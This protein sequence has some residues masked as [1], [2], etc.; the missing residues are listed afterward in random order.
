[1]RVRSPQR[2]RK[3]T[4]KWLNYIPETNMHY[5][6][7]MLSAVLPKNEAG[8][9]CFLKETSFHAFYCPQIVSSA[10]A[11]RRKYS[12]LCLFWSQITKLVVP[13]SDAKIVVTDRC[14]TLQT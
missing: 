11:L 2:P 13:D 4:L 6:F 1:V 9:N 7:N 3:E 14:P 10:G 12:H 8:T 5:C